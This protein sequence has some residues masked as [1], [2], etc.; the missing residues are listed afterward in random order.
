MTATAMMHKLAQ[1]SKAPIGIA[2]AVGA[3]VLLF[4]ASHQMISWLALAGCM[5]AAWEANVLLKCTQRQSVL[6]AVAVAAACLLCKWLL[7][8][9]REAVNEFLLL[10]L[11]MWLLLA[12]LW[13]A[14]RVRLPRILIAAL[15]GFAI[16]SAWLSL[17]VLAEYDRWML[18]A[19]LGGVWLVDTAA[20]AAGK[21]FGTSA[22]AI[23]ISPNKTWEG[24]L[25]ALLGAF[26]FVSVVW[27]QFL[28][29]SYPHWLML[30][31]AAAVVALAV[32]GDL[33]ES[34]L[35][36]QAG[37]KDSS[38]LLGA[39]GGILDR[40]DSWLPVLPFLALLSTLA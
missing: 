5:L 7:S 38:F 15:C 32:L 30:V 26:V 25:G 40:I 3:I 4:Y 33:S 31:V 19:G 18:I 37:V 12:P 22:L 21:R 36:R 16:V 24:V 28:S 10:A 1:S 11:L 8:G 13:L 34:V 23:Q 9:S 6:A 29:D 39:Q 17:V 35:K 2:L 14:R 27:A 20:W